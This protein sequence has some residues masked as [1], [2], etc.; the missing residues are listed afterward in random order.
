MKSAW[1]NAQGTAE[2]N[3]WGHFTATAAILLA[4]ASIALHGCG[5]GELKARA[6][7]EQAQQGDTTQAPEAVPGRAALQTAGGG[8]AETSKYRIGLQI[9]APQPLGPRQGLATGS[10]QLGPGSAPTPSKPVEEQP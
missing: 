5:E 4:T 6:P 1:G 7:D 2:P 3:R 10:V 9:G 8:M